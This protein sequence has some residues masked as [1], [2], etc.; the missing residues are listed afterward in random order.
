MTLKFDA[1]ASEFDNQRGL[2]QHAIGAWMELIDGLAMK[3]SMEI[4][5]PGIGTGRIALPIAMLGHQVTGADISMS[6]LDACAESADEFALG[7]C[8]TLL[9]A[10]AT[11]MPLAD[12]S[13]DIGIVSQLLYLVD[14]WAAVL[15]ELARLVVL[16]GYVIH[17]AEPTTESTALQRWSAGWREIIEAT[18]YAHTD[19]SPTDNDVRAEFLR[20]WP[21]SEIRELTSWSF[22]QS[23][24][25]AMTDYANRLRPLY[26]SV[27]DRD[28]ADAT[29]RFLTWAAQEF[30]DRE[31]VLEG[32]VILTALI[33]AV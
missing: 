27:S 17:L 30:P 28:W 32:T 19:V 5:E 9:E 2:P 21:D 16:G 29:E 1:L 15:D 3:P 20:R 18:G 7:D 11:N 22:G 25:A 8:V 6:M 10:D 14:D 13:F 23:V 24:A 12:Q 33:A 31:V 4:V 26:E